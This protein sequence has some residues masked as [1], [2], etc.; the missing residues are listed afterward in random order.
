VTLALS[1]HADKNVG[2]AR[3]QVAGHA[4]QT[5]EIPSKAGVARPLH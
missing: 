5:A 2:F 1:A 3:G 4:P